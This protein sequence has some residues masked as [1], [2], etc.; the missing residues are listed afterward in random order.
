MI[1]RTP[2]NDPTVFEKALLR[3]IANYRQAVKRKDKSEACRYFGAATNM[4]HVLLTRFGYSMEKINKLK[5]AS[6]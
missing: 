5:A 6:N 4:E 1:D 3:D 2:Y